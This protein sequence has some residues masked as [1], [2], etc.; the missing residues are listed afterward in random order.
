M[1]VV[2]LIPH[3]NHSLYTFSSANLLDHKLQGMAQG[4]RFTVHVVE[5]Q[6]MW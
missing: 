2:N 4:Y 5:V 6:L 1:A 3:K